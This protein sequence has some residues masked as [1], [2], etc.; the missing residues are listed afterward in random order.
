M[1][2]KDV[3]TGFVFR[4]SRVSAYTYLLNLHL[5]AGEGMSRECLR[6]LTAFPTRSV[7]MPCADHNSGDNLAA[8][9]LLFSLLVR[10]CLHFEAFVRG[11][12]LSFSDVRHGSQQ[13]LSQIALQSDELGI[14][15]EVCAI[16]KC[17]ACFALSR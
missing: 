17:H 16:M 9:P 12:V 6:R 8:S 13:S 15:V 11:A 4:C 3:A 2:K 7:E 14:W 10:L 5:V 1:R